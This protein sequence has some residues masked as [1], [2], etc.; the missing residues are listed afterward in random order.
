[1]STERENALAALRELTVPGRRA[2]LVAAAWKAGASVVAIAEAARAKSRQTIYDDL[3]SRGVVIDPRNRPKERNMPAP[4][5]V[6]GLN[7]I[8]DLEDNDGPVARAI[9]RAR[10]DLASPGLNAEA[11]RLMALSMAVAQYNELRARLAEEEDA[12]AERDRIRHLVD[13]R[14]EALADPNSK[15][16]WLHGHQAYVRAVDDA[17]RAIDTWKTTAETLMNLASFRRGE[18]ADRLVDAY[19]QHILTAGH[20]PVV[21]PHIDVETE[22]AQLHEELDAEH[23]RRSALAAQTLHHAPQET[24]R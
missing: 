18:D 11:R 1:M 20:P 16:S 10:D 3:K 21:K 19:E 24:L 4:I 2:D 14:W 12:R 8:T 23:T 5:T 22:A 15:G 7:G 13:I 6:E 17:H 9:L